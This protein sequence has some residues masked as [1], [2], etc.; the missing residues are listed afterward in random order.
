MTTNR[1]YEVVF[2]YEIEGRVSESSYDTD[3]VPVSRAEVQRYIRRWGSY[4]GIIAYRVWD[5]TDPCNLF[6]VRPMGA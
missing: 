5:G 1:V 3:A 6:C 2:S 4:P